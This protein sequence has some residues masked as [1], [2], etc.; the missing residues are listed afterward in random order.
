VYLAQQWINKEFIRNNHPAN[1]NHSI[2]I[3]GYIN[4]ILNAPC[5]N[6]CCQKQGGGYEESF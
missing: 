3:Y 1:Y 5:T 4:L 2:F 6:A